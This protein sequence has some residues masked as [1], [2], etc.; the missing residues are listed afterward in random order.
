MP[1][2]LRQDGFQFRIYTDDHEPMHVH[3]FK[4]GEELII[5]LGDERTPVSVRENLG[6]SRKDERK[7][8]VIAGD[9]Q[10]YLIE[11]WREIHG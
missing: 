4:A 5:N 7:A 2:M 10:E 3:V 9:N 8:L 11:R 1:T 6:M